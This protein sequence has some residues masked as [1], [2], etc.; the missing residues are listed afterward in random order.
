MCLVDI[1]L[2]IRSPLDPTFC[3]ISVCGPLRSFAVNVHL[4]HFFY[5]ITCIVTDAE[6]TQVLFCSDWLK[7]RLKL[8]VFDTR[9]LNI[10]VAWILP[11]RKLFHSTFFS[12]LLRQQV[13]RPTGC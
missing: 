7:I 1:F 11:S 12:Y 3:G 5:Q 13:D 4:L 10:A 9:P 8:Q 6:Y 2:L